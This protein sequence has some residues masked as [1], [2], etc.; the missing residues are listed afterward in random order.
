MKIDLFMDA[1][2]REEADATLFLR[3]DLFRRRLRQSLI[4]FV[5]VFLMILD[6][7]FVFLLLPSDDRGGRGMSKEN[8]LEWRAEMGGKGV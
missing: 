3:G 6:T 7:I 4:D 5:G 1:M 8:G 2:T